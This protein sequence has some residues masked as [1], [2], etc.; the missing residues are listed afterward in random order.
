MILHYYGLLDKIESCFTFQSFEV[1][2]GKVYIQ[3][4]SRF[5]YEPATMSIKNPAMFIKKHGKF[6]RFVIEGFSV[7][8][9]DGVIPIDCDTVS[10][11]FKE[12]S[13]LIDK[14]ADYAKGHSQ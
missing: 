12:A 7:T 3:N 2:E 10:E 1:E 8:V 14:S 11:I 5:G 4:S 6:Y 9:L 13:K